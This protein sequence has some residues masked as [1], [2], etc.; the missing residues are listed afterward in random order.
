MAADRR[1]LASL[2]NALTVHNRYPVDWARFN[3]QLLAEPLPGRPRPIYFMRSAWIHSQ[4]LV[5]VMWAGDQQTDWTIGDGFPSVLP[6]GIG[7]GITGFPYYAT[8]IAGYQSETTVPTSEELFYRWTAFGALSPVMR[9]HHGRD[10]FANFQW[11]HDSFSIAHFR[12]WA[13]FHQ[14]LAAY[15]AGSV[16]S[17]ERD[18]L[19]LFRLTALEYPNDDWAWRATDEYML[20]DRILVAPVISEGATSRDVQLPDGSWYPLLGGAAVTGDISAWAPVTEIP[21]FVPAGTLLVLYPDAIDTVYA[22]P[23]TP[24]ATSLAAIGDDREVRLWP[25]T[26][27]EAARAAWHDTLGTT[28]T[29]PQWT[30]AGRAGDAPA[31]TGATWNGAPV[32]WTQRSGFATTTVT[33]DGT[34]VLADG[35]TL[36]IARGLPSASVTVRIYAGAP[37]D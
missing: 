10:A 21:A 18:G 13:R 1:H 34:L 6:I 12:R 4:P 23:A 24:S 35:G 37:S 31:P 28:A 30:W 2:E 7:L 16:A 25:G 14:Q 8:D 36:T 19:P 33:G 9:T 3:Q 29:T 32:T 22:A 15:L 20:G 5:Q 26:A 27:S 11:Q 17:F